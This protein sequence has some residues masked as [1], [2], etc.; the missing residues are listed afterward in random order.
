MRPHDPLFISG[1]SE[2]WTCLG[3]PL[4]A[5]VT[6]SGLVQ[7]PSIVYRRLLC[8]WDAFW[9]AP[10]PATYFSRMSDAFK[11]IGACDSG[12]FEEPDDLDLEASG[13]KVEFGVSFSGPGDL[14]KR[15]GGC[16]HEM[17]SITC[18]AADVI[19]P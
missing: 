4:G 17:A 19:A 10:T 11:P 16:S 15:L 8:L 7:R 2:D 13:S 12:R 14:C 3:L 5:L 9:G 18:C 6:G 1:A